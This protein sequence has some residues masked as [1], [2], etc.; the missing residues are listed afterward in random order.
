MLKLKH[1]LDEAK[2]ADDKSVLFG[3]NKFDF[4][5]VHAVI[6]LARDQVMSLPFFAHGG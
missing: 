1:L 4:D 6:S 3:A 2:K 5:F